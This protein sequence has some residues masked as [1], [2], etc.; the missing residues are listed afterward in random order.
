SIAGNVTVGFHRFTLPP[1]VLT[2]ARTCVAFLAL[3]SYILSW[4]LH[5]PHMFVVF[6]SLLMVARVEGTY[7]RCGEMI[8]HTLPFL[9]LSFWVILYKR[10]MESMADNNEANI[11]VPDM[12]RELM[13]E[14]V[15]DV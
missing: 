8:E 3:A 9:N 5:L 4:Y 10:R 14:T 11:T 12:K 15:T 13:T 6:F 7:Q 1:R 2:H